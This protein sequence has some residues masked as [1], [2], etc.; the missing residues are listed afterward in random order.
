MAAQEH[1]KPDLRNPLEHKLVL[2]NFIAP[3]L[4]G[5]FLLTWYGPPISTDRQ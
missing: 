3:I 1:Y 4:L 5:I 2:I